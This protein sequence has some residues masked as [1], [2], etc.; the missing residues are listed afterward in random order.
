LREI[1]IFFL[2]PRHGEAPLTWAA[3]P[4]SEA[5]IGNYRCGPQSRGC[6]DLAVS[7]H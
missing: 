6:D 3:Q 7:Q 4:K 2:N 1:H 5:I